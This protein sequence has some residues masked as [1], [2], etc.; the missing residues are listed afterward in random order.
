MQASRWCVDTEINK[1]PWRNEGGGGCVRG[2]DRPWQSDSSL[3]EGMCMMMLQKLLC[4]ACRP[5][6]AM[7]WEALNCHRLIA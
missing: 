1:T 5:H 6:N 3:G 4:M 7:E 2:G